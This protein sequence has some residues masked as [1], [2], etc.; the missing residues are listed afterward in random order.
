MRSENLLYIN[1]A[2]AAKDG[3]RL[4]VRLDESFFAGLGQEE[5]SDGDVQ[6]EI[7]VRASAAD[8]YDIDLHLTGTVT[9]MCDR[10]LEPLDLRIDTHDSLQA[11][12]GA[13]EDNDAPELLYTEGAEPGVDLSWGVYEII[14]TSL[15]IQ[16]MHTEGECN[17]E[18]TG[19][20]IGNT[21][22]LTG[23]DESFN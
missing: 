18:M 8:I 3:K 17:P 4:T 21:D 2:Q 11:K 15:P 12:D 22:S 1:L 19:Y 9:V 5:I 6:A 23:E 16:R 14:E 7:S 20:I 13:P 10:C